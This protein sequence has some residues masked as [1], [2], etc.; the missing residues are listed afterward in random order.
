MLKDYQTDF[1]DKAD[2]FP[3]DLVS[4][5]ERMSVACNEDRFMKKK[6]KEKDNKDKSKDASSS[7]NVSY[8]SSFALVAEG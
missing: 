5:R 1:A 2:N 7:D 4:M 8:G 6:N 3:R